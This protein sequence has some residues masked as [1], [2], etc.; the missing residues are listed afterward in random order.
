MWDATVLALRQC[1]SSPFDSVSAEEL[2]ASNSRVDAA[3]A[4]S[5]TVSC[6]SDPNVTVGL[7]YDSH[8]TS[9][10]M[11]GAYKDHALRW[12]SDG[13]G[14]WLQVVFDLTDA[15]FEGRQNAGADLRL[16]LGGPDVRISRVHIER[17]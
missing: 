14:R 8:D 2:R 12:E 6:A 15:R 7:Q 9:A 16:V 17:R 11:D 4:A 1:R 13:S 3:S 5:V 10:T